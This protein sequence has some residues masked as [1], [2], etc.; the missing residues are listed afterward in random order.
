MSDPVDLRW[1]WPWQATL[2]RRIL[3]V[4]IFVLGLLAGS[5]FYLDGLRIRLIEE[6]ITQAASE[7]A[8][9]ASALESV[10]PTARPQFIG[11]IGAK[12]RARFRLFDAG[13]ELIADSWQTHSPTFSLNNPK[14]ESWQRNFARALDE[15]VD[16]VVGADIPPTFV[17]F[18]GVNLMSQPV[19][20]Q[21][22][23]DRTHI[24]T[25]QAGLGGTES[26][27]LLMDRNAR[28][29]RRIVRSERSRLG[30]VIL[31][32]TLFSVFL[33]LFLGRTIVRP[34]QQLA[35][36]AT[37]VRM[38]RDREVV[39]PRL[40][41][42]VDEIG[43]LARAVSDMSHALHQRID[44]TEM[45]AAD[46]AHELKNPLASL[47]S[48]VESLRTVTKPEL[49]AQL[50][51]IISDDVRRLDRLITDIS[52]LSRIDARLSRAAFERIDLVTL[53]EGLISLRGA[54]GKSGDVAVSF[55][56]PAKQHLCVAG[57]ASQL[58]RVIENL[59]DNAVS[60]S[61]PGSIVR[62]STDSNS[63]SVIVTV[64]DEGPGIADNAREAIFERFHSHRPEG[65]AFGKH[66]GLGLAI[67]RTIINGHDGAIMVAPS[68][69][70]RKGARFIIRLPR[71][72]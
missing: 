24:L 21:L 48:A 23:P 18:G 56:N 36:A 2:T 41:S 68:E 19:K 58:S 10:D 46:V 8:L 13:G 31:A 14:E 54:R 71:T 50:Q 55:A 44:A 15:A 45:F 3:A 70:G 57:E 66:S 30:Y 26:Q 53:I 20:L 37:R 28:D 9:A 59:L 42:R 67:A 25:A 61:P 4:N 7:A 40:P 51:D 29:I 27:I 12:S 16:F 35:Q 52:E 11:D 34:L 38:G 62:V 33:S 69:T 17:G 22:A 65:E 64:E 6:R 5:L 49:R 1:H 39:V 43:T 47:S 60:F 63:D 32:A 72:P